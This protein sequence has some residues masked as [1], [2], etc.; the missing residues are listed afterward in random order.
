MALSEYSFNL[1]FITGNTNGVADSMSRL[2]RNN[3]KD[4]AREYSEAAVFSASIIEKFTLNKVQYRIISSVHHLKV[5]HF[6][7]DRTLK[8]LNVIGMVWEF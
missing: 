1:M 2:C 8:R 6:G 4:A 7:L 5:G 3:T